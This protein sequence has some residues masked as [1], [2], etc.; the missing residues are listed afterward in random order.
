MRTGRL[1]TP[2]SS[3]RRGGDKLS[4]LSPLDYLQL[5]STSP[6]EQHMAA[7]PIIVTAEDLAPLLREPNYL[8]GAIDALERAMVVEHEGRVRQANAA[9]ETKVNDQ[10]STARVN[11]IAA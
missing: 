5:S 7:D 9:D 2:S 1:A 6:E 10:P 8:Q 3:H 11:I 4:C